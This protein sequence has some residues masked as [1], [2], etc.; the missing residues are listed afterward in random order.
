MFVKKNINKSHPLYEE[1]ISECKTLFQWYEA[2]IEAERAKY[3]DWKGLDHPAG[4]E[5]RALERERNSKLDELQRKYDFLFSK[6]SD[7]EQ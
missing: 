1:Y 4:K 7:D 5:V 6:A 3:P 2:K